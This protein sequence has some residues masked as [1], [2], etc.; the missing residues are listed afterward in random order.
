MVQKEEDRGQK[1]WSSNERISLNTGATPVW[2]GPDL[3][4]T[5]KFLGVH[6]HNT[7]FTSP[8]AKN[9]GRLQRIDFLVRFITSF[10][11]SD[12]WRSL[13]RLHSALPL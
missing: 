12:Q 5:C 2:S 6:A 10:R 13:M 1:S 11:I 3:P 4:G 8:R 7:P 9:S